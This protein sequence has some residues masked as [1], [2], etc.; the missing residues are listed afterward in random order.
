MA[1]TLIGAYGPWAAKIAGS[2]PGALSLRSGRFKNVSAWRRMA[3]A[4]VWECL[5]APNSIATP[6]P[7]VEWIGAYD[8]LHVEKLSWQLPY[9]PRT[10][11]VFLKPAH[12][13]RGARLPAL[14]GLHDH[15]GKKFFGWRK[16]AQVDAR[17]HP[18]AQGTP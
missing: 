10:E 15:G 12:A 16:I 4:R 17:I 18:P 9:G 3:R 7:R 8:G 5:A 1:K 2:K 6:K 13:P 11:A 14:L